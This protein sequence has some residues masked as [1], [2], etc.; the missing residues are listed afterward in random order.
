[1]H[2]AQPFH[3]CL[4][5]GLLMLAACA[6]I[7]QPPIIEPIVPV[8]ST[9]ASCPA[10]TEAALSQAEIAADEHVRTQHGTS[11]YL[12]GRCRLPNSYLYDR[13][14]VPRVVKYLGQD[15]RFKDTQVW[16]SVKRRLVTLIG[17]V[18]TAEQA[19]AMERSVLLV[20]DVMGVINE[21]RVVAH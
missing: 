15:E 10:P 19:A 11:C 21:L 20:D 12:S 18:H 9:I 8:T 5:A 2:L 13:E 7:A 1:M 6:S 3:H 16:V 14:L 4:P 17:C